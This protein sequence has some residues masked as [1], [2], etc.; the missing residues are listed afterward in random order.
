M[1]FAFGPFTL[2]SDVLLNRSQVVWLPPTPLC[3]LRE[4]VANSPRSVPYSRLA[5]A[6]WLWN[7]PSRDCIA[8]AIHQVRSALEQHHPGSAR[9]IETVRM[10]GYRFVPGA[11]V[12]AAPLPDDGG[13]GAVSSRHEAQSAVEWCRAADV[14]AALHPERILE[15]TRLYRRALECDERMVR[16]RRGLAECAVW[17]TLAGGPAERLDHAVGHLV[18]ALRAAPWDA[19][20]QACLALAAVV[21]GRE[22]AVARRRARRALGAQRDHSRVAWYAGLV[23]L[24]A[25]DHAGGADLLA[26]AAWREPSHALLRC[27]WSRTAEA[28]DSGRRGTALLQFLHSDA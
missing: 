18:A 3:V 12:T 25:G 20:T 27:H 11:S 5:A 19:R 28:I 10:R 16:A 15:T 9:W 13:S 2:S 23:A 6:G 24:H 17:A 22:L 7:T 21:T 8:R 4:L 1:H 26:E 14:L